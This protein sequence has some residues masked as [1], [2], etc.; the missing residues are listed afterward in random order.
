M[1]Q[2]RYFALK[3]DMNLFLA[4]SFTYNLGEYRLHM[5]YNKEERWF[6]V[7]EVWNST[8]RNLDLQYQYIET[9]ICNIL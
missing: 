9:F 3:K 5:T 8:N 6:F 1:L 2:Y 4:S 7:V